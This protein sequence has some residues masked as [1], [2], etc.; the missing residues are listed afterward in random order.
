MLNVVDICI[1]CLILLVMTLGVCNYYRRHTQTVVVRRPTLVIAYYNEDLSWMKDFNLDIFNVEIYMKYHKNPVSPDYKCISLPNVGRD[2]GSYLS[3]IVTNYHNLPNIV[4]F[5]TGGVNMPERYKM[6]KYIYDNYLQVEQKGYCAYTIRGVFHPEFTINNYTCTTPENQCKTSKLIPAKVRPFGKW[7]QHY[8]DS[9]L[10]KIQKLG[11]DFKGV[12]AVSKKSILQH[13]LVL[14]KELLTQ[15][16]TGD[17]IEVVHY[18]ERLW[19]SLFLN[20]NFKRK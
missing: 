10:S 14:Y 12:F 13:P 16:H 7:Y 4:L 18:M 11:V 8:I 2:G 5:T 9:D 1:I 20:T 6:F 3:Y 15:H 19:K 17:N